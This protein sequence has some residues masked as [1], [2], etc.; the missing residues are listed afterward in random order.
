M[1]PKLNILSNDDGHRVYELLL[2]R[3]K[4]G[5]VPKRAYTDVS[6]L[7]KV[8]Q[9]TIRRIFIKKQQS[10]RNGSP[11]ADITTKWKG[12]T[13]IERNIDE[14]S[15]D[16]P[17]SQRAIVRDAARAIGIAKSTLHYRLK[18]GEIRRHSSTIKP[19]LT[20]ESKRRR[21]EFCFSFV[22]IRQPL[23]FFM[24]LW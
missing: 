14:K 7:F 4:D 8:S 16:V 22:L 15:E 11:C 9:R 1:D 3:S 5:K 24:T 17:L 13:K 12:S 10:V 2:E 23:P 19:Y 18:S 20:E 21:I 6:N